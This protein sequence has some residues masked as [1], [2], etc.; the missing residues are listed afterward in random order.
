ME[1]SLY[2]HQGRRNDD[3]FRFMAS[4][5]PSVSSIFTQTTNQKLMGSMQVRWQKHVHTPPCLYGRFRF[6]D[7]EADMKEV[8]STSGCEYATCLFYLLFNTRF[9]IVEG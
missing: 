4:R 8:E 9:V 1:N 7:D 5:K 2:E 6:R 3:G